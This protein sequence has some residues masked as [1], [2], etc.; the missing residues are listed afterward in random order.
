MLL[1]RNKLV[2]DLLDE[3]VLRRTMIAT[4]THPTNREKSKARFLGLLLPTAKRLPMMNGLNI[5][6]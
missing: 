5:G 2:V 1:S 4:T 6:G 3:K